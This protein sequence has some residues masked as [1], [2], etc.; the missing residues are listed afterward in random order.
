MIF[1][2]NSESRSVGICQV[3]IETKANQH[4]CEVSES[5]SVV[6]CAVSIRY[7]CN[8]EIRDRDETGHKEE[9]GQCQRPSGETETSVLIKGL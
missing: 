9:V 5:I 1:Q 4:S 8:G 2:S 3:A 6:S 7:G